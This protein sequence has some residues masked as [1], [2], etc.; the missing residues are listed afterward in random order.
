MRTSE[1]IG[2]ISEALAK[3]QAE[4]QPI[5]KNCVNHYGKRYADLASIFAAVRPALS[6]YGL[7]IVQFFT[8]PV[9]PN[10]SGVRVVT[11]L[12]H[13]SGEWMES[14]LEL[15]CGQKAQE[16]GS[17]IT[18]GRRYSLAAILGVAADDDDDGN[19]A[20]GKPETNQGQTPAPKEPKPPQRPDFTKLAKA[21][22]PFNVGL[23]CLEMYCQQGLDKVPREKLSE[24][25]ER[26]KKDP[27]FVA[28]LQ[29]LA[30]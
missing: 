27:K 7:A 25:L 29:A 11:R 15:P 9:K 23:G 28:E 22:Q 6:K 8:D 14:S 17:A 3:A 5:P 20:S 16:Y 19:E 12:C 30:K 21:F 24:I 2:K 18:Y 4:F 26:C 13:S 1:T 10:F